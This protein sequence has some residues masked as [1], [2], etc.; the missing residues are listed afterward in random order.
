[1][2]FKNKVK[3]RMLTTLNCVNQTCE[4]IVNLE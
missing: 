3:V 1:M 4:S 2:K